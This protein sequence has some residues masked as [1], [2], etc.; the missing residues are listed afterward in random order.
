M[1][2][3]EDLRVFTRIV[4][5]GSISK[6]AEKTSIAKSAVSRRLSMLEERY[7][8]VLIDRTP[9]VWE[10]TG[11]G[12]ELYQRAVRVVG[13]MD[14]IEKDFVN[15]SANLSGPLSVSVPLEFGIN[16]LGDVLL[17]FKVKFPDIQL[18]IDFDD[19]T[20]DLDRENYDFALRI[21]G[22]LESSAGVTRIGSVAHRLFAAPGYVKA[23][24]LP[25]CLSDLHDHKL[26]Y[27]GSMRRAIW[28]FST[29][30]GKQQDIE[31]QP[32]LNSNSGMFLLKATIDGLGVSRLPDFIASGA[33]E[34]G[35]LVEVLSQFTV[36]EWGIY[37]V[38]S[39][40]RIFNRRMRLFA[41]MVTVFC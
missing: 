13:E 33:V 31:F 34:G 36:P 11:T 6:A 10:L 21:T 3:I 23:H 4:E 15:T 24:G 39:E 40:K 38:H 1:G 8:A 14:G 26:L 37:L 2:Q 30:K 7:D 25:T 16:F 5:Q 12:R 28:S 41:E 9:G 32:F 17:A 29:P 27:F 19:R 18:T 22:N 35:E 20:I